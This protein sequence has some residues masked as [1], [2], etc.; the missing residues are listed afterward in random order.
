MCKSQERRDLKWHGYGVLVGV[1][2]FV[3]SWVASGAIRFRRRF[4]RPPS[5]PAEV[6]HEQIR[7]TKPVSS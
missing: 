2:W 7:S 1:S 4:G 5:S 6:R 3:L